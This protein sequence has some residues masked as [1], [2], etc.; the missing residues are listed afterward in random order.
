[1]PASTRRVAVEA[2]PERETSVVQAG[3]EINCNR[4]PHQAATHF[5]EEGGVGGAERLH[6][7][8][9]GVAPAEEG[10]GVDA[11]P[12]EPVGVGPPRARAERDFASDLLRRW[13][14]LHAARIEEQLD[15]PAAFE[16]AAP[17]GRRGLRY[18]GGRSLLCAGRGRDERECQ[19]SCRQGRKSHVRCTR[20]RTGQRRTVA[21]SH[22][23]TSNGHAHPREKCFARNPAIPPARPA[24]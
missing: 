11:V 1:M 4:I 3:K 2:P 19:R 5:G 23:V 6:I 22:R 15:A 12:S 7:L 17:V 10:S 9:R 20:N 8:W 18:G 21:Q 14:V 16:W 13:R 24:S